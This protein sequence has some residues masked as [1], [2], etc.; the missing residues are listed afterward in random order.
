MRV[1]DFLDKIQQDEIF[2]LVQC[3]VQVPEYLKCHFSQFPPI[4]KIAEVSLEDVG[5][6]MRELC[7]LYGELKKPRRTLISSFFGEKV[8]LTTS[9]IKWYLEHGE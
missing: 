6:Y 4:Y 5:P 3:S 7:I 1:T 2:G 9:Q 8:L